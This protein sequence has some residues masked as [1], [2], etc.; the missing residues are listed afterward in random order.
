VRI[1]RVQFVD[2]YYDGGKPRFVAGRDYPFTDLTRAQV[3]AGAAQLVTVKAGPLRLVA[4]IIQ[5]AFASY[6][7]T[8]ER[9]ETIKAEA[10]LHGS[11]G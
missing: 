11:K 7:L 10:E 9:G 3:L 8:C 5:S 6:V 2:T 1:R 4:H